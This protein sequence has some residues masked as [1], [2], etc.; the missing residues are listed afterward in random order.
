MAEPIETR[1]RKF[2]G[3][4]PSVQ[5]EAADEIDR[6]KALLT[7]W[8]AAWRAG[9]QETDLVARTKAILSSEDNRA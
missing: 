9:S 6:M 1:L 7:E 5:R 2:C 4:P 8:L 3:V